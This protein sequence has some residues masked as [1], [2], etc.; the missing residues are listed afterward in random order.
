M[1]RPSRFF[2]YMIRIGLG[3][4]LCHVPL[5]SLRFILWTSSTAFK[6][7]CFVEGF[8]STPHLHFIADSHRASYSII[9]FICVR[10]DTLIAKQ[11]RKSSAS[12]QNCLTVKV[13]S[14]VPCAY[15]IDCADVT[16]RF[17]AIFVYTFGENLFALLALLLLTLP[18]ELTFHVL[19]ALPRLAERR[20][21][22]C[23][24]TYVPYCFAFA[25]CQRC[26]ICLASRVI[27]DQYRT[28]LPF[29]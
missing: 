13:G 1:L 4:P 7:K 16:Q 10:A 29:R 20:R 15:F 3:F 23:A 28:L 18:L 27:C 24:T 19:F 14:S 2:G 26:N 25:S 6:L 11:A 22:F 21:T 9:L 8:H 17:H 12:Y 5:T